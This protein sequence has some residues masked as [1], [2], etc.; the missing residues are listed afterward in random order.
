M[1]NEKSFIFSQLSLI[2]YSILLIQ[3]FSVFQC[4]TLFNNI[5]QIYNLLN[6]IFIRIHDK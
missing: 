6:N 3:G 5:C 4:A 1:K 2:F